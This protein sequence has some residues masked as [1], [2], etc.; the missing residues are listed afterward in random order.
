M[1][2]N[3][4]NQNQNQGGDNAKV[5]KQYSENLKKVEALV[6]GPQN[7]KLPNKVSASIAS[8]IVSD[9][10]AEETEELKGR[11]KTDLKALIIKKVAADKEI[12]EAEKKFAAL[13]LEKKKD[14]NKAAQ[15]LFNQIDGI[16][17]IMSEYAS[18]LEE[19]DKGE[20]EGE[21]K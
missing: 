1:S 11:I 21:E 19:A 13:K 9:L 2:E 15:N 20:G 5:E 7:L 18:A 8:E 14:F 3:A 12:A 16:G 17:T 10:F 4:N 6:Q